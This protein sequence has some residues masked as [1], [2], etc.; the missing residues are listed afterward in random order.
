MGLFQAASGAI[1]GTIADQYRDFYTVPDGLKSTAALFPAVARGVNAGRGA[2]T[3]ASGDVI[4]N[5]SKIVV[6]EGFGLI[7]AR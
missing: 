3:D 7:L 2:N 4:T 1:S 6:P 5:G